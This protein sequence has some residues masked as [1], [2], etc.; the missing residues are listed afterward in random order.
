MFSASFWIMG[1]LF[2][3]IMTLSPLE[4]NAKG[5]FVE[6]DENVKSS[7]MIISTTALI[8]LYKSEKFF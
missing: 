8:H 2:I 6:E 7:L 1:N 5:H 3:V 4:P